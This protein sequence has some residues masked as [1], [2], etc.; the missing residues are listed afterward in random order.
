M[1]TL[2]ERA[3]RLKERAGVLVLAVGHPGTPWYAKACGLLT[4]LYLLAPV[5]LIPDFLPVVGQLD[6]LL[7]VPFG[8]RLTVKLVPRDVWR[9]CEAEAARRRSEPPLRDRRGLFLVVVTWALLALLG[10]WLLRALL[11]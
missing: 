8:I 2:R 7:L 3:E 11:R 9:E 1:P 10:W 5:D 6:D 4:V